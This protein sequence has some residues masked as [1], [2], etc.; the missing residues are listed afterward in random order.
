MIS[1]PDAS[2]A[3]ALVQLA[4]GYWAS[5]AA[6]CAARLGVAD[7]LAV[8]P[9]T[10]AEIAPALQC[11]P[12]SLYRLLRA[13]ASV[14]L[15]SEEADGRFALTSTGDLLRGDLPMSFRGFIAAE[16]APGHWLPW[17]RLDEAVRTGQRQTATTLGM[18]V[19]DYY[20][21]NP[22]EGKWF[23]QGM[24]GLSMLVISEVLRVH[25]F[26]RVREI[27]DVGGAFGALATEILKA[28]PQARGFVLDSAAVTPGARATIEAQDLAARCEVVTG[29]F[30]KGVPA[31]KDCYLLKHI[32]HDWN[33]DEC[34]TILGHCAK[35]LAPD[36]AVVVVEMLIPE[37]G[38]PTPSPNVVPLMDLNMLVMLPGRERT[39]A[40][41]GTLFTHAGLK[42][43]RVSPTLTP[44]SVLEGRRG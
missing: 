13:C 44:F 17:G 29:D 12:D 38:L 41:Y 14:G 2:P 26:S 22:E 9:R 33:D 16:T 28:H 8:G 18:E 43:T 20:G 1:N 36:G 39:Q 19:W 5:Q 25:D 10:A 31:G 40:Q 32:L 21:K 6:G 15:F 24:T 7:Q 37:P 3:E 35:A 23:S 27:V 42:L 4:M 11:N 34:V 30:F